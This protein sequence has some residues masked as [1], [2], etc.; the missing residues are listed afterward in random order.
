MLVPERVGGLTTKAEQDQALETI[1]RAFSRPEHLE[2][3]MLQSLWQGP[4]FDP[5]HTRVV[6]ADGRVVSTV[7]IAPRTIRFGPVKVPAM[8]IGPVATH[9][10]YRKRNFASLA[11]EDATRYMREHGILVA[12]L[13]GIPGFYHRFGYYPFLVRCGAKLRRENAAKESLPGRLRRMTRKDLPSVRKI[14]DDVTRNRTC[15]AVRDDAV[16]NWLVSQ[17]TKTWLFSSPKVILDQ[18]GRTRGYLTTSGRDEFSIREIVVQDDETSCRVALGAVVREA[19]R[20]HVGEVSL[21][22]LPWDD[23]LAL[24]LRQHV[25]AEFTLRTGSTGGPLMLI[26]DF[27]VL[28]KRLEPLF[29]KRWAEA[30]SALPGGRFTLESEIGTVGFG[31]TKKGVRIGNAAPRP[32]VRVPQRWLSGLLTGY[33][34]VD[35]ITSRKGA[36]IPSELKPVLDILFPRGWPFVYQGDDY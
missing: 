36:R 34:A 5:D 33:Y 2:R 26:V 32:R 30:H 31:I 21:W 24:F 9:D 13:Q 14:Y 4:V 8:T 35:D 18:R 10:K 1:G 22:R 23:G 17:G 7:V 11:M 20:R 19:K 25:D 27:P 16:W 28:V 15:A 12:Y 29:T 3:H 6:V